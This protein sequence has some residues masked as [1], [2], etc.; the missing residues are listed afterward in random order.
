MHDVVNNED[1]SCVEFCNQCVQ[2]DKVYVKSGSYALSNRKL[3]SLKKISY[4]QKYYQCN[5]VRFIKDFFNIVLLDAQAWILMQAWNCSHVLLVCTRGFGKSTLID[6]MLM[7]K[8][9]LY[10]NY[11]SY[12]CSGSSSQSQTTFMTL[13]RI[14][15]DNIDTMVG[16]TGY[17]FK[18]EIEVK[19]GAGDGFSHGSNGFTYSLYN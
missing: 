6:L 11:W 10:S 1:L 2:K 16:S 8:G 17:I 3:E 5:P 12:I 4:I 19:N 14:A 9:M 18:Q 15:N 13:E 7:A